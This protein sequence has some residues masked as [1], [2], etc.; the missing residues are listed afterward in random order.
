MDLKP[1]RFEWYLP[2]YGG[3]RARYLRGEDPEPLM[4]ELRLPTWAEQRALTRL[5][6]PMTD[7]ELDDYLAA[8]IGS[9]RNLSFEGRPITSGAELVALRAQLDANLLTELDRALGRQEQLDE[10]LRGKLP[11]PRGSAGSPA[12]NA[13]TAPTAG[14]EGSMS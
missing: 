10:G 1:C 11:S 12:A 8:H 3:N 2:E 14:A 7:V 13:G 5:G 4:L 9:I 6:R